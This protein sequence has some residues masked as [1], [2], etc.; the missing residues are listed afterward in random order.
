MIRVLRK[1]KILFLRQIVVW[2]KFFCT[3]QFTI[4]VYSTYLDIGKFFVRCKHTV[5]L[6]IMFNFIGTPVQY[7]DFWFM[8][9]NC[10][11]VWKTWQ[12]TVNTALV[13][14]LCIG[15]QIRFC[16]SNLQGRWWSDRNRLFVCLM[17]M[18]FSNK[19][20]ILNINSR[21]LCS[22]VFS[23]VPDNSVV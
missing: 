19:K 12:N 18:L 7:W 10:V 21:S 9:I 13:E 2:P 22:L 1:C 14:D 11:L 8:F 17:I 15:I 4:G 6:L 20:P 23:L 5:C 3:R 16:S